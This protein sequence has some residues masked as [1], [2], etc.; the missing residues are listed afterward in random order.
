MRTPPHILVVDDNPVNVD[1]L[2][3]RL[4]VHGYEILTAADGEEALVVARAKQPD[5]I[6]LDVMMPKMDGIQ[7]CRELRADSSLPFM[8]IIL[9]TAKTD[10]KDVV[11]GLEAGGDEYLTKPVDQAALVARVQSMLRVKAL[12]DTVQEQATRLAGQA[13]ELREWNRTLEQRVADQLAEL[14]R[15]G[16]LKRFFSPQLAEL[17]V[18]GGAEDPLKTHRRDVTVVFLDLRGFTAFAETSEPEEVMGVLREYHA[19]MGMLILTHEGTLERF[20]G[21]GIM[22]FF[23]DPVPLPNPA[24]RAVRMALEMRERIAELTLKWRKLGYDLDFGIGIAQGYAT[25]GAI[26]FEGRWDY[27]AIGTVTNLAARLCGE[28]RPGQVLVSQRVLAAVEDL[29]DVETVGELH[30][31]GFLKAV[32]AF[33]LVRLTTRR[34]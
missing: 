16:R 23:N 3:T 9:V 31:K 12:H 19:E 24:E 32:P 20:T 4:A 17:I 22:V 34:L 8:P 30:L 18:A 25:I 6:L 5:L 26:G 11:A 29:V 14:Q 28:A 27:G 33:N 15:V 13:A 21:D 1:I 7:V 10:S 2:R